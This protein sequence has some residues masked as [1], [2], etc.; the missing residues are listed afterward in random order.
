MTSA[1]D[2]FLTG[3]SLHKAGRAAEAEAAYRT[4]LAVNPDHFTALQHLGALLSDRGALAEAAELFGKASRLRSNDPV[5]FYQFATALAELDRYDEALAAF[6]AAL[7]I[8]SDIPLLYAG[9]GSA[10]HALKRY[11]EAVA[12]YAG[13]L[14]LRPDDALTLAN[15]AS[16]LQLT[17]RTAEALVAIDRSLAL[18][19]DDP[20][21]LVVRALVRTGMGEVEKA[22]ADFEAAIRLQP[23]NIE[24][25]LQFASILLTY[26]GSVRAIEVF[27]EILRRDPGNLDAYIGRGGSRFL[28]G[29]HKEAIA[30]YSEALARDSKSAAA[31]YNRSNALA[32]LNRHDEALADID[33]AL[34]L[35]PT[36]SEALATRFAIVAACCDFT[37]RDAAAADLTACCRDGK[38]T[39]PF[40]LLYAV[41]DPALHRKAAQRAAGSSSCLR[42]R[43]APHRRLRIGYMSADLRNHVVAHQIIEVLER[44]DRDGFETIGISLSP[45]DGTP[46]SGRVIKAFDRF[47]ESGDCNDAELS[48]LI[49]GLDLDVVID[50]TGHTTRGRTKALARRPASLAVNFLGYPGTLGADYIDYIIADTEVI[51]PEAEP[52]YTEKIV[53][54]PCSFLP[55]DTTVA[56]ASP[57]SRAEAGL[58]E[59][60]L[61]FGAFA[62]SY[63]IEST[64]FDVWMRLLNAVP[65]SVLWLNQKDETARANL[66]REAAARA[67]APER[68][69]FAPRIADQA[70]HLGRLALT[71]IFLDTRCYGAHATASD[72]LYAGV[73]MVTVTGQSF[74]TRVGS[75]MLKFA[76]LNE[77]IASDLA[78]YESIALALAQN[79]ECRAVLR[80]KL[81]AMRGELFDM[82][83]YT[84]ALESAY[85]TMVDQVRDDCVA[86][87]SVDKL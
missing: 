59:R 17:G 40:A 85:R 37:R 84:R 35:E 32:A 16:A 66:R 13:A 24:T 36:L 10:L 9:R 21:A 4:A 25:L 29:L 34:A 26:G 5:I 7:A 67:V 30:D 33:Q 81:T 44:H 19:P 18:R 48:R 47:V 11:D 80:A 23:D 82:N 75:G 46:F 69:I 73:P 39:Y 14:K 54:L 72:V 71:D 45:T 60:G 63:K 79:Q 31:F 78:H 28:L 42:P 8:K 15:Q 56:P 49:A 61:V 6:D 41:D 58:P 22:L 2:H 53:R 65:D 83:A 76:G 74:A 12:A 51:P 38:L 52:F 3:L 86:S 55:R 1:D 27:S 43:V 62:N 68:L 50:L 20:K 70:T 77:L 64:L 87:F 57:P